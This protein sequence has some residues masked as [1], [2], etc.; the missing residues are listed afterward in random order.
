MPESKPPRGSQAPSA[1][2]LFR[3]QV[4]CQVRTSVLGG[5]SLARAVRE[6]SARVH[7]VHDGQCRRV[8]TR[9]LYR[10]RHAYDA[11]G[12]AALEPAARKRTATSQ[13]LPDT[14][15]EFVRS[16]K[17]TDPAAS[18]PEIMRR[19]ELAG[20]SVADVH[21]STVWRL[22]QRLSL[23]T[24]MRPVKHEGDLW[25][26]S[27]P[28]RMMMVLSDGKHFRA[29]ARRARRVAMFFL[30]DA[31][32][33]GLHVV[34]GTEGESAE[35]FLRG[36]FEV[37]CKF[38]FMSVL[39]LDN[40]AGFI[41]LETIRIAAQLPGVHLVH[42]KERY[43]EGHG[44]IEKFNQTMQNAVLRSLD[45]AAEVDPSAAALELRLRHALEQYND[46]PHESL[47]QCT[48]RQ[49]FQADAR[50]LAF[51]RD[52]A[53]LRGHFVVTE[54]RKVSK[55]H[56]IQWGGKLY[57][58]PYGLGGR[59][60]QVRHH[61]LDSRRLSVIH[62]DQDV[63]LSEVDMV[64]NA[65]AGRAQRKPPEAPQPSDLPVPKTAATRAFERD[66]GSILTPDGGF[67]DS[68]D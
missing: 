34:V 31:T 48:P 32:R 46:W 1:A 4:V 51:P 12:I 40:G 65:T 61:L 68:N 11:V 10:W 2:A 47:A 13:A 26:F 39:Y 49:A 59:K 6:V 50:T 18:V 15:V 53:E 24:R 5:Q 38:G 9:T 64:R 22:C 30:D 52:E 28:H 55:D 62:G 54:T 58:A 7:E 57:E 17:Q 43:P 60:I 23:P 41:S 35:L 21:R 56:V 3:Y 36:L 42:G 29:G 67:L 63:T 14:W 16:E 33:Y 19:A 66:L 37:V 20:L 27:Y 45:G 44:K 8:S 25:R